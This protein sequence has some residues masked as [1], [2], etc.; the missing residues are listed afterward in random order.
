M[1]PLANV[2]ISGASIQLF[3]ERCY[4]TKY[5]FRRSNKCIC[6]LISPYLL[7][8][9]VGMSSWFMLARLYSYLICLHQIYIYWGIPK[10]IINLIS[11]H[12]L[13]SSTLMSFFD[14]FEGF[15][16]GKPRNVV[17]FSF[18]YHNFG[19]EKYQIWNLQFFILKVWESWNPQ[20]SWVY[21]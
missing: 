9:L 21:F 12:S 2:F 10:G 13:P 17:D 11:E 4:Q 14:F 3:C 15:K 8:S 18:T 20:H 6:L 5:L 19:L 7:G 16:R 1:I